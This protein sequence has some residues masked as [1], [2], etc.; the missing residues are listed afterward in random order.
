[1]TI[2]RRHDGFLLLLTLVMV[3]SL[4]AQGTGPTTGGL[5]ARDQAQRM[6][7]HHRRALMI[8]A[9]PDDEDTEVLTILGRSE[10][11]ETAYLALN[12]GE[13]GQNLIGPEL[14][15]GL[16]LI[17]TGELLAARSIDGG[18]QFFTRTYDYGFSKS[19]EEAW[20]FWPRDS[21]LKDVVRVIRRFK[22]QIV[23]AVFSGTPRDG[24]GQHQAAG[25]AAAEAFRVAGDEAVF[26]ELL[27]EEGL[28]PFTPLRRCGP[29]CSARRWCAASRSAWPRPSCRGTSRCSSPC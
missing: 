22:P 8:G 5:V 24:H 1:M 28:A 14:G 27:R 11:A 20:E 4:A 9:H 29:G 21:V 10:G 17:R 3:P 7:G 12:R 26:P 6:R 15:D 13:G 23:I 16:G 18:R 19:I 2:C 25:W